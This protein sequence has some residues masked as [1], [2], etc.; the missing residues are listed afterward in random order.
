LT[1][2]TISEREPR[3]LGEKALMVR[4]EFVRLTGI[5]GSGHHGPAFAVAEIAHQPAAND[6]CDRRHPNPEE[7]Q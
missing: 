6:A 1:T 2:K 4:T 7:R 3:A 5:A